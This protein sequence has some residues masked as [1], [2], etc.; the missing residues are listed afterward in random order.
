MP[1][2]T[3]DR[4]GLV[5]NPFRDLASEN[6]EDVEIFHVNLQVDESLTA[7]KEEVL[8]RQ[9]RAVVAIVGDHGAGKTERLRLAATEAR[10]RKAF[11]VYVDVSASALGTTQLIAK[12][13][14]NVA[15]LG[16]F[17]QLFSAPSWY[18]QLV[19]VQRVKPD[20]FN[21]VAVGRALAAALNAHPPAVVLLNDLHN[22]AQPAEA[23]AITKLLQ[24]VSD[25]IKPGVLVLFDCY[26]NYLAWLAKARPAFAGRINRT[27]LLPSLGSE[28]AALL[29]AKKLLA[30]R[31]VEELDPLFPFDRT[32]VA[33]LNEA[34][35]GNPRRLL[36]LADLTLQFGVEH[37]VPRIDAAT[38]QATMLTQKSAAAP[39]RTPV[40]TRP[41]APVPTPAAARTALATA[42]PSGNVWAEDSP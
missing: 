30:K 40:P 18:R 24:E 37:R 26:P 12:E 4:Y 27:F 32:G 33:E 11:T 10:A 7:I 17:A 6:L 25:G 3:Y 23:Q 29:L 39:P 42:A 1:Q 9:N 15:A 8:E 22:L 41:A 38:V 2:A 16:G 35:G 19:A 21:P 28:E 31:V 5:S 20:R 34:A 14:Q 36:E 13:V